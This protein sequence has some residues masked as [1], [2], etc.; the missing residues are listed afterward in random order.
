MRV[1]R[2]L[3]GKELIKLLEKYGYEITNQR[4]S[5]IKITTQ[6][7]G[8]HHIVIPN[9]SPIKIGTLNGIM[10]QVAKHFS[11]TKNQVLEDLF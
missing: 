10:T 6:R 5:H 8:E 7:N 2:D 11:L 3:S 1:P 9:H 4:G